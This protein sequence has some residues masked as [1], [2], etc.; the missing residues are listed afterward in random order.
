MSVE[1]NTNQ[2]KPNSHLA[3][4][5]GLI[6][7]GCLP[8]LLTITGIGFLSH[9]PLLGRVCIGLGLPLLLVSVPSCGLG[10]YGLYYYR[11]QKK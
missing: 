4:S 2:L 10:A 1:L 7:V 8:I 3:I 5:L 6:T 9:Q 11:I